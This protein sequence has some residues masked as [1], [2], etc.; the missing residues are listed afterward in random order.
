MIAL[1]VVGKCRIR[2]INYN[3]LINYNINYIILYCYYSI[4]N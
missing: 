4:T 2:P 3:R 1:L